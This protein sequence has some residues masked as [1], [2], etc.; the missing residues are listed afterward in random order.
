MLG[1]DNWNDG[2]Q[3]P[4]GGHVDRA[5]QV[6]MQMSKHILI[7]DDTTDLLRLMRMVFEEDNHQVSVLD[8]GNDVLAYARSQKPDLIVLDLVL[9]KIS[10]ISVLRDLKTDQET[11]SIQVIVYTASVIDAE[12][13]EQMIAAEPH[14]FGNTPVLHKPFSLEEL[15]EIV[16]R[17]QD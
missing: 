14:V 17:P 9:G 8:N 4:S 1:S 12:K 10:G 13:T 5:K 15:L 16:S 7:V 3:T 11:R 2:D 6:R